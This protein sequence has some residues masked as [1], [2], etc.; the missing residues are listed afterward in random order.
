M[1]QSRVLTC[2]RVSVLDVLADVRVLGVAGERGG[3]VL[4]L[5]RADLA[6]V[7]DDGA[8]V[9]GDLDVQLQRADPELQRVAERA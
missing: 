6:V 1:P 9:L 7:G 8:A 5:D 3:G 2:A 4:A